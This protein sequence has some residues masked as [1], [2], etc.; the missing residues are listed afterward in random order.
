MSASL[1]GRVSATGTLSNSSGISMASRLA[2]G[3]YQIVMSQ[4]QSS[5]DYSVV[6]LFDDFVGGTPPYAEVDTRTNSSFIVEW[7][8]SSNALIDQ[9]FTF[10]VYSSEITQGTPGRDGSDADVTSDNIIRAVSGSPTDNQI[11]QYDATSRRLE[12]QDPPEGGSGGSGVGV[13]PVPYITGDPHYWVS[14]NKGRTLDFI[15]HDVDITDQNR[16]VNT[17]I[18]S[19]GGNPFTIAW[20]IATAPR[21]VSVEVSQMQADNITQNATSGQVDLNVDLRQG[22]TSLQ[23]FRSTLPVIVPSK[24]RALIE[25][26]PEIEGLPTAV[27]Q[28]A[29]INTLS[30]EPSVTSDGSLTITAGSVSTGPWAEIGTGDD[31]GKIKFLLTTVLRLSIGIT[32]RVGSANARACPELGVSGTGIQVLSKS[33]P[34]YRATNVNEQ[35]FRYVDVLVTKD[36][37]GTLSILNPS[38]TFQNTTLL[39]SS[40]SHLVI[41]P[42]GGSKGEKGDSVTGPRGPAGAASTVPGPAGRD[43]RDGSDANVTSDNIIRAVAGTPQDDQIIQFDST[44]SRLEFVDPPEGGGGT[45]EVTSDSIVRAVSGTPTDNQIIQFDSSSGQLEFQDPPRDGADG[46]DASVTS[47]NIIR[48]VSGT[49]TDNQIIQFDATNS[50]L[51]F[52]DPSAGGGSNVTPVPYVTGDPHYWVS[53]GDARVVTLVLHDVDITDQNRNTNRL[54]ITIGGNPFTIDP[55]PIATAPRRINIEVSAQQANNITSND[56]RGAIDINVNLRQGTTT[57]Q[58]IMP[59]TLPVIVEGKSIALKED[60]QSGGGGGGGGGATPFADM[61][62]VP[63]GIGGFGTGS[64]YTPDTLPSSIE[65]I[66]SEKLTSKAITNVAFMMESVTLTLSPSTPLSSNLSDTQGALRF[67]IPDAD[68]PTLTALIVETREQL[69]CVVTITFQDGTTFVQNIPFLVNSVYYNRIANA[70]QSV[71]GGIAT[72]DNAIGTRPFSRPNGTIEG[73]PWYMD[74]I[75]TDRNEIPSG[76]FSTNPLDMKSSQ[77]TPYSLIETR[78]ITPVEGGRD[79][80]ATHH[81]IHPTLSRVVFNG[82]NLPIPMPLPIMTGVRCFCFF[83]NDATNPMT[84]AH[85]E[86]D[87][88]SKGYSIYTSSYGRAVTSNKLNLP[89][90]FTTGTIHAIDMANFNGSDG[91]GE[92]FWRVYILH[93]EASGTTKIKRIDLQNA[94]SGTRNTAGD[95]TLPR[96]ASYRLTGTDNSDANFTKMSIQRR[97]GSSSHSI[98]LFDQRFSNIVALYLSQ[99]GSSFSFPSY[100]NERAEHLVNLDLLS[101][102]GIVRNSNQVTAFCS[103]HAGDP[104][105]RQDSLWVARRSVRPSLYVRAPGIYHAHEVYKLRADIYRTL[106]TASGAS[107]RVNF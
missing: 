29:S 48:A 8:N 58:S 59:T 94:T 106:I 19:I 105:G 84:I 77:G 49:P 103:D 51:E 61:I 98:W 90:E 38:V 41:I 10:T 36:S 31:A 30:G 65:L 14:D 93:E 99:D 88:A 95:I 50:R 52:V 44:N 25:D 28:V 78:S 3:R 107:I 91:R 97:F 87:D 40:L 81:W 62:L 24:A 27:N 43:G 83:N 92:A 42:Q 47:A 70:I 72:E 37:I 63:G 86:L 101:G 18:L 69:S 75:A 20:P 67:S 56:S 22:S 6:P 85:T 54:L 53:T 71:R 16:A 96:K 104:F 13:T 55:W 102:S 26:I 2:T 46:S 34:Y 82:N 4:A 12:F 32:C 57:L 80:R 45:A 64:N 1:F 21:R 89:S 76:F 23:S 5:P 39:V 11:I 15:I 100:A 9:E 35:I 79:L 73:G 74:P 33:N 60:I 66:L 68:L 7:R 17:M